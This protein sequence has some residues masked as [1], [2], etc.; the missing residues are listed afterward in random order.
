MLHEFAVFGGDE[1]TLEAHRNTGIGDP[2]LLQPGIGC[3][4]LQLGQANLHELRGARFSH[5]PD[6]HPG[7]EPE[8]HQKKKTNA[9]EQNASK[10][11]GFAMRHSGSSDDLFVAEIIAQLVVD[12][13]RLRGDAAPQGKSNGGLFDEHP[14]SVCQMPYACVLLCL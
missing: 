14:Q 12:R 11:A 10:P 6:E 1:G 5:F 2:G 4:L 8:L 9:R 3:L 13:L 7:K